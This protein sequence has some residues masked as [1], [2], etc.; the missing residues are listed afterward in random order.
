MEYAVKRDQPVKVGIACILII[1]HANTQ[2]LEYMIVD[3]YLLCILSR[4]VRIRIG[5]LII[6]HTL[7]IVHTGDHF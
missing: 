6:L 3:F 2:H 5:M 4:C 1:E 7:D